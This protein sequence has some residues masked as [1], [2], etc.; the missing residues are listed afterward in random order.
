MAIPAIRT[1]GDL[2]NQLALAIRG[3]RRQAKEQELGGAPVSELCILTALVGAE[4]SATTVELKQTT[5][6]TVVRYIDM[7]VVATRRA[8]RLESVQRSWLGTKYCVMRR[9]RL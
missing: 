9:P 7:E 1:F 6:E 4:N 5:S 8:G 3:I 2:H